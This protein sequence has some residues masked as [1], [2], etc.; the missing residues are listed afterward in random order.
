HFLAAAA[1]QDGD[2]GLLRVEAMAGGVV[3][4]RFGLHGEFAQRMAREFGFDAVLAIE[5]FFEREDDQHLLYVSLHELDAAATPGPE[6]RADIVDHRDPA[7]M[8]RFRQAEME[9]GEIDED[10]YV[11]AAAVG[12]AQQLVELAINA[13]EMGG[14]L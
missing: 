2:P 9:V 10:G 6:L 5:R 13:R 11:G 4:A 3:G 14:D 8:E 1:G 7:G 12:L